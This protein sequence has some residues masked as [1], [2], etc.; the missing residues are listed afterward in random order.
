MP[1]L[2]PGSEGPNVVRWQLFLL[3]Q[4]FEP[5][6]ADGHFGPRTQR[7]TA[8]FQDHNGLSPDGLVGR[9]TLGRAVALGFPGF[10]EAEFPPAPAFRPLVSTAE[11]QALFGAFDYVHRPTTLDREAI[12]IDDRWER[13][14]IV[15]VDVPG[16]KGVTGAPRRGAIA[17]HKL[18]APQLVALWT[19]WR[20]RRL[21]DRILSFDGA[22]VPRFVRGSRSALSNHAFG[23]AFDLNAR[24]NALGHAPAGF[25][26]R[27]CVYEL[28]AVANAHGWYWGGH[29]DGRKDGMH[30]ELAELRP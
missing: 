26:Q 1:F 29:F 15:E 8:E 11:R 23:T 9:A 10:A 4:G 14:N 2:Q 19:D 25:G 6:E 5:G 13:E 20:E 22:F 24:F 12:D 27:G 28:V 16:L 7:A 3:G 30:F 18:A 21:L 17:F